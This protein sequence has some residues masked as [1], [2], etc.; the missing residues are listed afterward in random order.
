MQRKREASNLFEGIFYALLF[1][2]IAFLAISIIWMLI[3]R[4]MK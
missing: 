4:W 2:A 1:E 3:K